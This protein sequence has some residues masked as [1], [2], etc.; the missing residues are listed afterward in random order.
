MGCCQWKDAVSN[1]RAYYKNK[2]THAGLV[3]YTF[4][5]LSNPFFRCDSWV[6]V[7]V[8]SSVVPLTPPPSP[9]HRYN[10]TKSRKFDRLVLAVS[11]GLSLFFFLKTFLGFGKLIFKG[12]YGQSFGLWLLVSLVNS[13]LTFKYKSLFFALSFLQSLLRVHSNIHT[14]QT[15][16]ILVMG[17][18]G[19]GGGNMPSFFSSLSFSPLEM[20]EEATPKY[21]CACEVMI[22]WYCSVTPQEQGVPQRTAPEVGANS[23]D[24]KWATP[25]IMPRYPWRTIRPKEFLMKKCKPNNKLKTP[26]SLFRGEKLCFVNSFHPNVFLKA[27]CFTILWSPICREIELPISAILFMATFLYSLNPFFKK[28]WMFFCCNVKYVFS[29]KKIP[30]F[31]NQSNFL[32]SKKPWLHLLL[33]CLWNNGLKRVYPTVFFDWLSLG[34]LDQWWLLQ[35]KHHT[36]EPRL[37]QALVLWVHLDWHLQ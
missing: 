32:K 36:C 5:R 16:F 15:N 13:I 19:G 21:S 22:F 27:Q 9:L 4:R 26:P 34:A 1:V 20:C 33:H 31:R 28:P 11:V 8:P 17:V 25:H 30:L 14:K 12:S 3:L 35:Q 24:S 29:I 23:G 37:S 7:W 18:W 6:C 10:K 2:G